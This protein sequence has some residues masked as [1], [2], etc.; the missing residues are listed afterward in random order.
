MQKTIHISEKVHLITVNDRKTHLFENLWTIENGV[1]YNA[2]LINDDKIA[3]IDTV[4]KSKI[5]EYF[6]K[7][8]SVLGKNAKVDYLIINHM[9]PDHSAAIRAVVDRF[10]G[11]QIIGNKMTVALLRG[12]YG[13]VDNIIVIEDGAEFD[14]GKHKLKIF[15]TPWLHWPETMMTYDQTDKVLFSGDAFGSFGSLDGGVFDD[16]VN[17]SFYEDEM[18]RYYA[19]IVGKYSKMVQKALLRLKDVDIKVI[20]P[21]HGVVWRENLAKI[22]SDYNRWSSYKTEKGVVI[23]FGTMYGNTEKM[24]DMIARQLAV[25]GIRNIRVYDSSKKPL[26]YIIKDIWNYKGLIIGSCA[27][28]AEAFPMIKMILDKIEN[29]ELQD[30]LFA[31]FG[32][33]GWNKSGVK[34]LNQFVERMGWEVVAPPAEAKGA[35]D[36]STLIQCINIADKMADKLNSIFG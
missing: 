7:I 2:Y 32:S 13:V 9:E 5:D 23:V 6:E 25:R 33:S 21:T 4:E 20:A 34:V 26:S 15:I 28:N 30:R 19:T 24:A 3:L 31:S 29:S 35:P 36:D 27:Y 22:V 17:I 1:A 10:P 18:L 12:F 11:I 16:E 8:D 14:L